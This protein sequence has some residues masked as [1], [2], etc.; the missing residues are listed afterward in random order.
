MFV[1]IYNTVIKAKWAYYMANVV[2]NSDNFYKD[3]N[4][5]SIYGTEY[6]FWMGVYCHQSLKFIKKKTVWVCLK[7][8]ISL[9]VLHK[10]K[11]GDRKK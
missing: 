8:G 10:N 7:W 1:S 9:Q 2:I 4:S 3:D 5:P 11:G 6:C